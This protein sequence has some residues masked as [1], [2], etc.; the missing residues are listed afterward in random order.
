[1]RSKQICI[2]ERDFV[3]EKMMETEKT[4]NCTKPQAELAQQASSYIL[5]HVDKKIT[6]KEITEQMHQK[7]T[8]LKN[9]Y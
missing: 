2:S 9:S 5:E 1:M 3:M 4:R 7:Q 8:Q 6:I